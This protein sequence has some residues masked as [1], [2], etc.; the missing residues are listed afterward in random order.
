MKKD[1]QAKD[2]ADVHVYEAIEGCKAAGMPWGILDLMA[3]HLGMP[4]KV[5]RAKCASMIRRGLITGCACGCRGDF[6]KVEK[7]L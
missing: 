1:I 6:E 7:K 4:E 3:L 5:V 2:I